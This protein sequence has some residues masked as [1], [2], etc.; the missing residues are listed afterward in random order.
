MYYG[1][2][3]QIHTKVIPVPY[4]YLIYFGILALLWTLFQCSV[5]NNNISFKWDP[6]VEEESVTVT[7]GGG[8]I[9]IGSTPAENDESQIIT[10]YS[11]IPINA[12]FENEKGI[13]LFTYH[14]II[15]EESFLFE[16]NVPCLIIFSAS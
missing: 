9:S 4:G 13:T 14:N 1:I 7:I 2:K 8:Y 3:E 6:R 15:P 5:L 12:T 11:S 16:S 10:S